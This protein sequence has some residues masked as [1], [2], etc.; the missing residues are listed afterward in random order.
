MLS[1]DRKYKSNKK[2]HIYYE[3][4][5]YTY[6]T[7]ILLYYTNINDTDFKIICKN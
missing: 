6:Y 2:E 4:L 5:Y 3:Y 1:I 7:Y